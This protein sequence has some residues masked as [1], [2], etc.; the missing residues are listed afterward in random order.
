MP[1]RIY[2][3]LLDVANAQNGFVTA[4][5][6]KAV[7]VN[8]L[9][10][11]DLARRGTAEKVGHGVYRLTAIP[12]TP[13]D[14]Y[15]EATL[16]PYGTRGVLSHETA[17][18]LHELCD[19]NPARIHIT[20]PKAFRPRRETPKLYVVHR[21]DLAE[22][23]KTLHEG[24]PIVTPFRAILDGI[25]G[26]LGERLLGQAIENGERRGLLTPAELGVAKASLAGL[27]TAS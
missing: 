26:R 17:L 6:A 25:E 9:R 21:F 10:L 7:G 8:P 5:D 13:L 18:D 15:M 4:E 14:G 24:I 11:Q 23:E 22:G 20:V 19:V 16:W 1:G 12:A 2:T 27:A 3:Q